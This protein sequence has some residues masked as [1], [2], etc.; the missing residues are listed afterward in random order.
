MFLALP[1]STTHLM[2]GA[3]FFEEY[4]EVVGKRPDIDELAEIELMEIIDD[5]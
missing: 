4:M 3:G 5:E 1:F 2:L